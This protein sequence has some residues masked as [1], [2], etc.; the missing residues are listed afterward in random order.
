M[1]GPAFRWARSGRGA[2][3]HAR[4]TRPLKGLVKRK[5]N[6]LFGDALNIIFSLTHNS[7]AHIK[8]ASADLSKQLAGA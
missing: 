6:S 8:V 7:L 4:K 1:E 3:H 5:P 2:A